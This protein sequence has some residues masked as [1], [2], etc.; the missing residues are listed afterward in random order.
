MAG[1]YKRG[2]TFWVIYRIDGKLIR[3]S[4][5]TKNERVARSKSKRL[6]YELSLGDLEW[7]VKFPWRSF[8]RPSV[9]T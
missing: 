4:L 9:N 8:W 3:K 1:L 2:K 7:P 5:G 6:E